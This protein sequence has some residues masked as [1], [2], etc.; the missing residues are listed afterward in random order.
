MVLLSVQPNFEK[1]SN[2]LVYSIVSDANSRISQ[3]ELFAVDIELYDE[4][5]IKT[6]NQ[7]NIRSLP[8]LYRKRDT[9]TIHSV[10]DEDESEFL[11]DD[12][13]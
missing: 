9:G 11:S 6:L 7:K 4:K 2:I 8:K 5:E 12:D 3:A 13:E 1:L 10:E